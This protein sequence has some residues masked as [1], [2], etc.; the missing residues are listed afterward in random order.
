MSSQLGAV[1]LRPKTPA[2][3]VA[4]M[5]SHGSFLMMACLT[6]FEGELAF[7]MAGINQWQEPNSSQQLKPSDCAGEHAASHHLDTDCMFVV[8]GF[9]RG[10]RRKHLTHADLWEEFWKAH[11][12]IVSTR[13]GEAMPLRRR[14]PQHHWKRTVMKLQ[15][16]WL[17][18]EL[19]G[20]PFPWNMCLQPVIPTAAWDL[21]RPGSSRST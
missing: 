3:D 4:V 2:S 13:S 11:D 18:V 8:N 16:N 21:S 15:T 5:V 9:A 17:R 7:C 20:T 6:R 10:R 14:S 1:V 12:A 19:C